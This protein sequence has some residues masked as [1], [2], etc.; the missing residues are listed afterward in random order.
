MLFNIICSFSGQNNSIGFYYSFFTAVTF[1]MITFMFFT[2]FIIRYQSKSRVL[3]RI[4]S[5]AHKIIF[6]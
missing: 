1:K 6:Q 2:G 4:C 5:Y 3:R